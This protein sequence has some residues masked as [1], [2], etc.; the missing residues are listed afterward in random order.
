MTASIE[1]FDINSIHKQ[2]I[3]QIII[4]MNSMSSF[5]LFYGLAIAADCEDFCFHIHVLH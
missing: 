4:I 1:Y 3:E 5:Q 2:N